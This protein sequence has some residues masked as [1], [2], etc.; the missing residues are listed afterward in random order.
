MSEPKNRMVLNFFGC[1]GAFRLRF[2]PA[3]RCY[4]GDTAKI[5]RHKRIGKYSYVYLVESVYEDGRTRHHI[6]GR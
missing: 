4:G 5:L 3:R 2:R 1:N 6:I